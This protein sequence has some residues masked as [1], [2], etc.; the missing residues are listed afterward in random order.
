[1]KR[2]FSQPCSIDSLPDSLLRLVFDM[3]LGLMLDNA[4]YSSTND[5]TM[6][7]SLALVCKKWNPH[8]WTSRIDVETNLSNMDKFATFTNLKSLTVAVMKSNDRPVTLPF[9]LISLCLKWD[10]CNFAM[11]SENR[12]R[13]LKLEN[14]ELDHVQKLFFPCLEKASFIDCTFKSPDWFSL[15]F[16]PLLHTL[17]VHS[18]YSNYFHICHPGKQLRKLSIKQSRGDISF[19]SATT[20]EVVELDIFSSTNI[21]ILPF[22]ASLRAL[23]LTL[24]AV[25]LTL[26]QTEHLVHIR[27]LT[28]LT[29]TCSRDAHY[30]EQNYLHDF[31]VVNACTLEHFDISFNDGEGEYVSLPPF[32]N[33]K[34][35]KMYNPSNSFLTAISHSV[36]SKLH[37]FKLKYPY[38]KYKDGIF[39]RFQEWKFLDGNY[40]RRISLRRICFSQLCQLPIMHQ[41]KKVTFVDQDSDMVDFKRFRQNDIDFKLPK[42]WMASGWYETEWY[43]T[44]P[45]SCKQISTEDSAEEE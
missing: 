20:L 12:L 38:K 43:L 19:V 36:K 44:N 27:N 2:K 41:V 7:N 13:E 45:F 42:H 26:V 3:V 16:A 33:L 37:V 15:Y 18:L 23:E 10:H 24:R 31:I 5:V 35:L 29:L 25:E 17:E 22:C 1:M 14:C 28:K 11:I 39:R 34:T 9:C 6:W 21:C 32:T 30:S 4:E 40:L 8:W